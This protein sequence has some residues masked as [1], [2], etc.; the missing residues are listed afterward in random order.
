[1]HRHL[2]IHAVVFE[3]YAFSRVM[4]L[5]STFTIFDHPTAIWQQGLHH[6]CQG[7][8][9]LPKTSLPELA[10]PIQL[11]PLVRT[12]PSVGNLSVGLAL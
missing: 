4:E 2:P 12:S 1:M 11:T 9:A 5:S 6:L 8:E 10:T 7:L 3:T